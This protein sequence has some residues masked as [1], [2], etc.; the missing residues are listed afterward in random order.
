MST[1]EI[2]DLQLYVLKYPDA[3]DDVEENLPGYL[4]EP[5]SFWDNIGHPP[6][7]WKIF[8]DHMGKVTTFQFPDA[9]GIIDSDGEMIDSDGLP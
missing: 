1:Q 4:V 5:C 7:Y 3:W 2:N 9:Q 8:K 6:L